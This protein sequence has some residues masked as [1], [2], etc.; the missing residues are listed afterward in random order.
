MLLLIKIVINYFSL[1]S[2]FAVSSFDFNLTVSKLF[3]FLCSSCKAL[4]NL[5]FLLC[6]PFQMQSKLHF[7]CERNK[8]QSQL[9]YNVKFIAMVFLI[10]CL[11]IKTVNTDMFLL[12]FGKF[13]FLIHILINSQNISNKHIFLIRSRIVTSNLSDLFD[14]D[15]LSK[16]YYYYHGTYIFRGT[17]NPLVCTLTNSR[18]QVH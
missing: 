1:I 10:F 18:E 13:L 4:Q 5:Y 8:I 12:G 15:L 7:P 11:F 14:C 2:F 16:D 3:F 6:D 17:K 9:W